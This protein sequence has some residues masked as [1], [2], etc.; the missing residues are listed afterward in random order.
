MCETNRCELEKYC[1]SIIVA[2]H[3]KLKVL[4][5]ELYEGKYVKLVDNTIIIDDTI[6]IDE[7]YCEQTYYLKLN[8]LDYIK[9]KIMKTF[10]DIQEVYFKI[11]LSAELKYFI[12][13]IYVKS[14]TILE[15]IK[16]NKTNKEDEEIEIINNKY[17]LYRHIVEN[18]IR[19][20]EH[21][22][23]IDSF[24]EAE[25]M[26]KKFVQDG[27]IVGEVV[28]CCNEYFIDIKTNMTITPGGPVKKTLTTLMP[29]FKPGE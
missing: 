26:K 16:K 8:N 22:L 2:I 12:Q 25:I 28:K 20:G 23:K 19:N 21:K 5:Q 4:V 7:K 18:N 17:H 6:I 14:D 27:Y 29:T 3:E 15:I 13:K 24:Y 11:V 10:T 9:N 1:G